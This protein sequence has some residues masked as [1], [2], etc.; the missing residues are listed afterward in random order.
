MLRLT[1]VRQRLGLTQ[2]A[3]ARRADLA[4]PTVCSI[5]KGHNK[6]WPGQLAAIAEV[7]GVPPDQAASLMEVVD[8]ADRP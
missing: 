1:L 8:D 6:P 5:E 7:L 4:A 3:L 2:A